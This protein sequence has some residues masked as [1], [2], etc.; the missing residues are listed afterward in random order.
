VELVQGALGEVGQL[1]GLDADGREQLGAAGQCLDQRLPGNRADGVGVQVEEGV[2]EA[3]PDGVGIG[4]VRS[5]LVAVE[6]LQD[7]GAGADGPGGT[8]VFR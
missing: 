5:S 3:A 4:R 7:I 1:E 8:P 2:G 6:E